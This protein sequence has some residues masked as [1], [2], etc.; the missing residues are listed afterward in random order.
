M[1]P[2]LNFVNEEGTKC[3][4][5]LTVYALS[6][7]GFCKRAIK[8]LKD[9]SIKFKYVYFDDLESDLQSKI[10]EALDAQFRQGLSFPFLVID[11]NKC[12]VGFDQEEWEEKLL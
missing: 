7:C 3:D 9:N 4:H 10:Q 2:N 11:G 1:K 8:F 6:T 5:D 12:L